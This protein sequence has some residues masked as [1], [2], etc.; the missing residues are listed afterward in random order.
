MIVGVLLRLR[1]MVST[2]RANETSREGE[3]DRD[4]RNFKITKQD[5]R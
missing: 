3:G 4:E 2:S 5:D 1:E